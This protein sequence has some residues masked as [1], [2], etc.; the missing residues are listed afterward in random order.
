MLVFTLTF[1]R[2]NSPTEV[3]VTIKEESCTP[4]DIIGKDFQHFFGDGWLVTVHVDKK[5]KEDAIEILESSKGCEWYEWMVENVCNYG[6]V[7]R[8]QTEY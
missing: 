4:L 5:T 1:T 6:T 7:M 2:F 8:P 3:Y